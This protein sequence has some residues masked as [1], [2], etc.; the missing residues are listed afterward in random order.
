MGH[1][2][3]PMTAVPRT[4][5]NWTFAVATV[6]WAM[7]VGFAARYAIAI[8]VP[9]IGGARLMRW[10]VGSALGLAVGAAVIQFALLAMVLLRSTLMPDLWLELRRS[11]G[12]RPSRSLT[13]A[14]FIVGIAPLA[15]IAG[16]LVAKLTGA[17]L[18]SIEVVGGLVRSAG[19]FEL[20]V[21]AVSLT[22]LPAIVEEVIFRGLVLGSLDE[23][24]PSVAL[25]IS[26]LAFGAFHLDVA[27]G[28]ATALLG[29]GF[30]YIVQTTGTLLGAM[31]AHGTYNLLVLL[32][33]RFLPMTNTPVKWQLVEVAA[34]LLVAVVAG[35][36]L[37]RR[38]WVDDRKTKRA[39]A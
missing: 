20:G 21:L 14:A 5:P 29:L 24:R 8:I 13:A 31:V 16:I 36:R 4:P 9:L 6:I 22:L 2:A 35:L 1:A 34:G 12:L 11:I 33:Q 37:G 38:R 10:L 32:T 39:A 26:A 23:L 19:M 27:Q 3:A 25:L 17:S 30:G 18:E 28:V 7:I 15:N